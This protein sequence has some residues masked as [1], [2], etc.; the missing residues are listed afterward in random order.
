[1]DNA[2][3]LITCSSVSDSLKTEIIIAVLWWGF[4]EYGTPP[5]HPDQLWYMV[6]VSQ[7]PGTCSAYIQDFSRSPLDQTHHCRCKTSAH[8]QEKKIHPIILV[9]PR[10][11]LFYM[12]RISL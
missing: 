8:I 5:R 9:V 3:R 11:S 4:L 2:S 7:G 10:M 12:R 6:R 1:M